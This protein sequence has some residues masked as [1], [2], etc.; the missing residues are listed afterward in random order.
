MM[1]GKLVNGMIEI[2]KLPLKQNGRDIFTNDENIIKSGGYKPIESSVPEKREG[3]IPVRYFEET[4][5]KIIEKYNYI[6]DSEV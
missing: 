5:D 2:L 1:F 3:F 4:E 6:S